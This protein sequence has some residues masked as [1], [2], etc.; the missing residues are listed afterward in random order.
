VPFASSVLYAT[1]ALK[2]ARGAVAEAWLAKLAASGAVGTV[3]FVEGTGTWDAQ[4]AA[5]VVG[6]QL[7]GRKMPVADPAADFA[8]VSAVADEDGSG[9]GWW[10]VELSAQGVRSEPLATID[11]LRPHARLDFNAVAVQRLGEPGQGAR[12]ASQLLD[13][14]AVLTAFE[15]LGGAQ[16]QLET[17]VEYAKTRRAFGNFIGANQAVKHRLADMYT[18]I[19]L[20]RG[21]CYY[22][23]WALAS[24]A[25]EL[26]VAAAGAR[27]AATA[28]YSFAAEETIEVHGGIGFAWE[29]DCH[30]HYRRAR[31]LALVLGNRSRW[32]DRLI[33]GL[34]QRIAA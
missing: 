19:E 21:H 22:G 13:V 27:L 11:V 24:G 32:S 16:V 20:A 33:A 34:Q 5:R 26:A 31:L 23:A 1:E 6:G 15:Q 7:F 14:A 4:P 9:Y 25:P 29:S 8:V 30:L 12:L 3:A 18:R 17:C 2:L 10:L 28:A